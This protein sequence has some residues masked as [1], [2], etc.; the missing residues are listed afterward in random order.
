MPIPALI[1]VLVLLVPPSAATAQ[2]RYYPDAGIR[3]A[4]SPRVASLT[5]SGIVVDVTDGKPL[6]ASVGLRG[7]SYGVLTDSLGRFTLKAPRAGKLLLAVS[8]IGYRTAQD[9]IEFRAEGGLI[10][11]VGLQLDADC[12]SMVP[13]G[14]KIMVR[15]LVTGLAPATPVR[16]RIQ[17]DTF[18]AETDRGATT[19]N[20]DRSIAHLSFAV[21]SELPTHGPFDVEVIA[22]GYVTW[23]AS[24]V[25]MVL[26]QCGR[27]R[28]PTLR[29]WLMPIDGW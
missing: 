27:D 22:N 7:T 23:K 18:V 14:M 2:D 6:F 19:I 12:E 5:I 16:V 8:K 4:S 11:Q 21:G 1:L 25:L 10:A 17:S 26:D 13:P 15:D 24:N 3:W 20:P 28:Q 9:T 29:A